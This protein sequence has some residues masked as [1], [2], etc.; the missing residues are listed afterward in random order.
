M[1]GIDPQP[2]VP[3]GSPTTAVIPWRGGL[4][5][6]PPTP[7]R[8]R[9]WPW[10]NFVF[11]LLVLLRRCRQAVIEWRQ[12][13]NY[14][15]AMHQR[16]W[17]REQALRD[18]LRRARAQLRELE[19]R[20]FGRKAETAAAK[21]PTATSAPRRPATRRRGQQPGRPGPARRNHEH[22]P[23]VE[24]TCELPGDQRCCPQCRQ[25]SAAT[26]S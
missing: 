6:V 25:P 23:T 9:L 13:A 5:P 17:R 14:Y 18:E 20:L 10:T 1:D 11:V 12:Q 2:L 15:R 22:L 7:V 16:A 21:T 26:G 3:P 19:Q 8:R 4:I 24:E